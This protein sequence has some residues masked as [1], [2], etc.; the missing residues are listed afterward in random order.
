MAVSETTSAAEDTVVTDE[1]SEDTLTGEVTE[2]IPAE[3]NAELSLL[4]AEPEEGIAVLAGDG[5]ADVITWKELE[6]ALKDNAIDTINITADLTYNDPID[7]DKKIVVKAGKTFTWKVYQDTFKADDLVIEEGGTFCVSV[8]TSWC[9]EIVEGNVTNNGTIEITG[10]KGVCF[11]TAATK[12]TG[13]FITSNATEKPC[14]SYDAVPDAMLGEQTA[15]NDYYINIVKDLSIVPTVSLPE[16]MTVGDTI[17]VTVT[18]LIE[19]VNLGDAFTFEWKNGSSFPRYDGAATPTLTEAG[20]LKLNLS[21]KK[22]YVIKLKGNSQPGSFD[23]SGTVAK[24]EYA[25]LYVDQLKGDDTNLGTTENAPLKNLDTAAGNIQAGGT[26]IL[27]NDYSGGAGFEKNVTVK[28]AEGSKYKLGSTKF[29]S[30]IENND[31]TVTLENVELNGFALEDDSSYNG[32]LVIKNCTGNIRDAGYTVKT[33]TIENSEITASIENVENLTLTNTTVTDRFHG[34][35]NLILNGINIVIPKKNSPSCVEETISGDGILR[36]SPE[37]PEKGLQLIQVP[38]GTQN[39][40]ISKME[41]ADTKDGQYRLKSYEDRGRTYIG[42]AERVTA[43]GKLGVGNEP[44]L[45][46][47]V[48]KKGHLWVAVNDNSYSDESVRWSGY[49]DTTNKVWSADD[50]PE[51]IVTLRLLTDKNSSFFDNQFNPEKMTVY[52]V[53]DVTGW[54]KLTDENLNTS[55]QIVVKDGQGASRDGEYFTFTIVYPKVQRLEQTVTM[56]CSDRSAYCNDVLEARPAE[57]ETDITYESSNPE[58]ASVDPQTGEI[59]AHKPGETEIVVRAVKSL[60]YEEAQASYKLTVS[61]HP[62]TAP[63]AVNGLI[64]NGKAQALVTQQPTA[65][66]TMLYKVNNG[67]WQKEL[68]TASVAGTYIISYKVTMGE[69]HGETEA[70]QLEV[71]ILPKKATVTPTG[72]YKIHGAEDPEL[73]WTAEGLVPGDSLKGIVIKRTAGAEVGTYE[74]TAEQTEN[75]NPNYDLTFG[76]AV[77]TIIPAASDEKL[78]LGKGKITLKVET[79][80]GISAEMGISE[81]ELLRMLIKNGTVTSEELVQ[82]VN[83]ASMELVLTV[84]EIT[85]EVSETSKE[86]FQKAAGDYTIGQYLD[87]SIFKYLIV[88]GVRGE[89]QPVHETGEK[90]ALSIRISDSLINKAENTERSYLVL[91]NHEGTVETVNGTYQADTQTYRFASEKFSDY[92]IA[93]KDTVKTETVTKTDKKKHH[94]SKSGNNDTAVAAAGASSAAGTVTSAATGDQTNVMGYG[95]LLLLSLVAIAGMLTMKRR[96]AK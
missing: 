60:L 17:E 73:T 50:M 95:I 81:T 63:E 92:A 12:G 37:S 27:L 22:P 65:E 84:K 59:T 18:N 94:S 68:P 4:A 35:K 91:R 43:Q 74:I 28:S 62:V 67:N 87:I 72:A 80:Q 48:D 53:K 20:T 14:I 31:V 71:T 29:Y 52:S 19:G 66:G 36:F 51:L 10:K 64:Y 58:V 34:V 85:S 5:E 13:T 25:L 32:K 96:S 38:D 41:L 79:D 77:F 54:P 82:M 3:E 89:A 21:A 26:I 24:R 93:Y 8:W 70:Q 9:Q 7:T 45:Q 57:A 90:L 76:K 42:I 40:I 1:V 15:G 30:W 56:D 55:V 39:E 46:T 69:A 75:A 44:A 47:E 23:V 33:V 86:L 49:T 16:K 78:E 83:G 2:Q 11:W 61:H 88:D 6:T